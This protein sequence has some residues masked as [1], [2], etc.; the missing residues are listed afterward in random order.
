MTQAMEGTATHPVATDAPAHAAAMPVEEHRL[1]KGLV[2]RVPAIAWL[3]TLVVAVSTAFVLLLGWE[4]AMRHLGLRAGDLDDGREYWVEE[5]R[6]VD[7]GP[8]DAVVLIGDSRI[9]FDTDLD[10]WQAL[11]GR[12]PIQLAL[13]GSNA[14][15]VLHDLAMDE[16]FAGLL[17]VGTAEFSY[18]NDGAGTAADALDYNQKQSPSQKVGHALYKFASRHLA[19]LDSNATLFTLLERRDWPEREGVWGPYNDVWKL[20]EVHDDRQTHL[21]SQLE[22]DPYLREHARRV[23][24]SIYGGDVVTKEMV[25]KVI[26]QAKPD[27]DRIRARG[28]EVVW[29]RP[30]SAGPIL[31]TE[32]Q[33][34]PRAQAWDRVVQA[35]ASTG[36]YFAD[37]PQMRQL[38]VPDWS[39]LSHASAVDFTDAYVHVLLDRVDWLKDHSRDWIAAA[40]NA[41]VPAQAARADAEP[42]NSLG[43]MKACASGIQSYPD[44]TPASLV[45][46]NIHISGTSRHGEGCPASK[47]HEGT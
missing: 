32:Q 19:F 6:K 35:T 24:Q 7:E 10:K 47:E 33:R 40:A 11:T 23:W 2:R 12:R 18:F 22:T 38:S 46:E 8:R 36:V 44:G 5:R 13:M 42:K 27:V 26:A 1:D 43:S 25:D 28:G 34:F 4:M 21:W 45:R 14:Q 37:Y 20:G 29:V 9:L 31:A 30:P 17:V 39:H 16:H 41:R 3:R 15:P